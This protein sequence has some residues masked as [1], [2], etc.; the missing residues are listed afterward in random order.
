MEPEGSLLCSKKPATGPYPVPD[1]SSPPLTPL[2][3]TL[4]LSSHSSV[5][6]LSTALCFQ[7]PALYILPI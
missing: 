3:S 4:I 5:Q 7:T 6:L 1:E 2:R